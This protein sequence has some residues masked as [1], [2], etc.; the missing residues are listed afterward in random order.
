M[1]TILCLPLL[2]VLG[3]FQVARAEKPGA[4][5]PKSN[6]PERPEYTTFRPPEDKAPKP[7]E[8]WHVVTAKI[9]REK[10]ETGDRMK[11]FDLPERVYELPWPENTKLPL[12][13]GQ[14][15]TLTILNDHW[16]DP[17]TGGGWKPKDTLMKVVQEGMIL[18]DASLCEVHGSKMERKVVPISYGDPGSEFMGTPFAVWLELFPHGFMRNFGGCV[19]NEGSPK[20]GKCYVCEKCVEDSAA[21]RARKEKSGH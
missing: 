2:A 9:E 4:G 11:V 7:A 12:I 17:F 18:M 16:Y 8:K 10:G 3:T 21:W 6:A 13:S 15:Y 5:A 19:T 14:V 1:K 20:T